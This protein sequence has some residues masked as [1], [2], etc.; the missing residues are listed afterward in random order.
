MAGVHPQRAKEL[1][2]LPRV[3]MWVNKD[4]TTCLYALRIYSTATYGTREKATLLE[5]RLAY[6]AT[7]IPS[8]LLGLLARLGTGPKAKL[9]EMR[10]AYLASVQTERAAA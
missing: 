4:H 8:M 7:V 5:M 9:S 2:S 3:G 1:H 10:A 6:L